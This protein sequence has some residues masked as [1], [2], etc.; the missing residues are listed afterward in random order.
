MILSL[1]KLQMK[2][3]LLVLVDDEWQQQMS[4]RITTV[5]TREPSCLTL[6]LDR[7]SQYNIL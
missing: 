3:S 6:S 1:Y 5:V 7:D 2:I 4:M